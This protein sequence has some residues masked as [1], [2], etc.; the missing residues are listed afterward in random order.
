MKLVWVAL[1]A[2]LV[3]G[4]AVVP[5]PYP[6]DPYLAAPSVSIGVGVPVYRGGYGHRHHYRRGHRPHGYYG[7]PHHHRR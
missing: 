2:L 6:Y 7:R 1:A 4:C 3:A 5:A